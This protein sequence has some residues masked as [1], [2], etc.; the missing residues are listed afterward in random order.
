MSCDFLQFI[1]VNSKGLCVSP[2]NHPDTHFVTGQTDA[3]YC[4][5]PEGRGQCYA[6]EVGSFS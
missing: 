5:N 3:V 4:Y 6:F 1:F 2:V